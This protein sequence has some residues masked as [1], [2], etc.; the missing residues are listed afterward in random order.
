[1]DKLLIILIHTIATILTSAPFIL[2]LEYDIAS[3]ETL[4]VVGIASLHVD[5]K[6]L[7]NHLTR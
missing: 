6:T 7:S 4:V 3:F 2:V 5:H 1:M